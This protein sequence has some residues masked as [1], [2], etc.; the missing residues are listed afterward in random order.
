ML[1][2]ISYQFQ[3]QLGNTQETGYEGVIMQNETEIVLANLDWLMMHQG[4][5]LDYAARAVVLISNP[6]YKSDPYYTLDDLAVAGLT[7][8]TAGWEGRGSLEICTEAAISSGS[9]QQIK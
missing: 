1:A 3:M 7:P 8:A 4:M 2:A 6:P 9:R 5:R